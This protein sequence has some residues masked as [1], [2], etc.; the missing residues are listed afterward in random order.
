MNNLFLEAEDIVENNIEKELNK[1]KIEEKKKEFLL[2]ILMKS[3]K[4]YIM[5]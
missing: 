2:T 1:L 4:N 5:E 3:C